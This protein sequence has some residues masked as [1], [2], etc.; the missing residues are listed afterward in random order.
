M[1]LKLRGR[2]H[3]SLL[4]FVLA[5]FGLAAVAGG[6]IA[7]STSD[8]DPALQTAQATGAIGP[9]VSSQLSVLSRSATGTDA[10]P[11]G[12]QGVLQRNFGF[13]G[14]NVAGARRVTASDGQPAYLVPTNDGVCAVDTSGV[15]CSRTTAFAGSDSVDLCS[16]NLAKGQIEIQWLLPDGANNV[17]IQHVD[18]STSSFASGSNV[19]IARFATTS[20]RPATIQ[21]DLSG[22][23]H[24]IDAGV[25]SDDGSTCVHPGDIPPASQLPKPATT[26]VIT[27]GP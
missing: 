25:P 21:W 9:A 6:A 10:L 3:R 22:E 14:P 16:P 1:R 5:A 23:H 12:E 27:Q 7:L 11:A 20:P 19:Y 17:S 24:S 2:G 26:G 4:T 15:L 18:G 8:T 13:V